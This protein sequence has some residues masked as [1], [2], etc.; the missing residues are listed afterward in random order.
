MLVYLS[1]K[2]TSYVKDIAFL[3]ESFFDSSPIETYIQSKLAFKSNRKRKYTYLSNPANSIPTYSAVAWI[4][5]YTRT[6]IYIYVHSLW[7]DQ[8]SQYSLTSLCGTCKWHW[9]FNCIATQGQHCFHPSKLTTGYINITIKTLQTSNLLTNTGTNLFELN[10]QPTQHVYLPMLTKY[11]T[12]AT[13][14]LTYMYQKIK[15]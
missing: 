3:K 14:A 10:I 15:C 8:Q 11:S 5:I 4:R 1:G 2:L 12:N 9:I 6:F 13:C 7:L